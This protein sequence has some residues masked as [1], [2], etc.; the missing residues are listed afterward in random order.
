M[1]K[2]KVTGRLST[3]EETSGPKEIKLEREELLV[4][5]YLSEKNRRLEAEAAR[6]SAEMSAF[7]LENTQYTQSLSDKYKVDLGRYALDM[8]TGEVKP[9]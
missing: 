2:E 1:K 8:S 3:A 7:Q 5:N 4:L 6:V 9:L